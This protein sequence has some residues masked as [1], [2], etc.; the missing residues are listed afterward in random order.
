MPFLL[1]RLDKP[2]CRHF[3]LMRLA[4]A[5][6]PALNRLAIS[7]PIPLHCPVPYSLADTSMTFAS[8]TGWN[9]S[10]NLYSQAVE[11]HRL[12]GHHLLDLTASNPTTIGLEFDPGILA[13]LGQREAL[14]YRP[15]PRGLAIAREA[16][17][18]YY[19]ERGDVAIPDQLLLT[20]STSE[21]YSFIFRLLCNPGDEVL[22]PTP[23]YPLFEFL[24]GLQDVRLVSYPLLY[25]HGWQIDF[26]SL[27]ARLT[28][29][30]RGIILV[31]PNNPTGSFIHAAERDQ[32][33]QLCIEQ[34]LALI[35]DEVFLDFVHS[36]S[37]TELHT[38]FA[39]NQEALTF[40]LS[41]LSK[42]AGLPQMKFAW[43]NVS[44]PERL[45]TD[46]LAR[47]EVIADT[48]LSMNAP[49]Q[50]ASPILLNSRHG[51]QRQLKQRITTN[52]SD[53][54][55]QLAEQSLASRLE[56][57]AGWYAILRVPALEP[58]ELLAID[59]LDRED[60]L[61]HPGHF[62]DFRADGHLI[63]SLIT[64]ERDFQEGMSRLLR[65]IATN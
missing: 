36:A 5:V 48:Y 60:V 37:T 42:I 49:I 53:L 6:Q 12:A 46:A 13:A 14:R 18:A 23:S 28:S 25:D 1:E 62:Y 20:T 56:V 19:R 24:A 3:L 22:V 31:H 29:C 41:G 39:A 17:C 59:L 11:R 35:V 47:L 38:S 4:F 63:V 34:D 44:G 64:P 21:G 61:V 57:E 54:D 15:D 55:R 2:F 52:L 65:R 32:L 33:N 30:T 10:S 51:F 40:T 8:R 26:A 50:L 7:L 45:K 9:L 27:R 16:V 43:L 58:D